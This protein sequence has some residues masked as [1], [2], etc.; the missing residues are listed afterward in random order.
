[1]NSNLTA[2]NVESDKTLTP[3]IETQLDGLSMKIT[4]QKDQ[5]TTL[6]KQLTQLKKDKSQMQQ[7][8]VSCMNRIQL[9]EEQ[10]GVT[11][12]SSS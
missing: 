4:L 5:N 2:L 9:L 7:H 3:T 8:V 11:N 1:M 6:Q 12:S 10:V